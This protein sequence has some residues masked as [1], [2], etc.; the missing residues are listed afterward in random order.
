MEFITLDHF[1]VDGNK[2]SISLPHLHAQFNVLKTDE[3]IYYQLIVNDSNMKEITMKFY[4]LEDVIGFIQNVVSNSWTN[5]EVLNKYNE[6]KEEGKLRLPGGLQPPQ[7]GKIK[8]SP[9]EIEYAIIDYFG[10]GKD[11]KV[12]VREDLYVDEERNP[13]IKFYLVEHYEDINKNIEYLLTETDLKRALANYISDNGYQLNDFK[14]IGGVRKFGYFVDKDMAYF[15]GIELS[16]SEKVKENTHV[17][18]KE[19]RE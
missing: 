4:T 19:K 14:Y 15:E 7:K 2:A 11:Y 9:D 13:Q 6:M 12:S 16:V 10:S 8:V 3:Y 5:E 18:R 1:G 17:K